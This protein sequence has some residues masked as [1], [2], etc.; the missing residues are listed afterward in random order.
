MQ[1]V[2]NSGVIICSS[3]VS[4]AFQVTGVEC[5]SLCGLKTKPRPDSFIILKGA[6][7]FI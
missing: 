6:V 4:V 1:H 3:V 5:I 2:Y 7:R